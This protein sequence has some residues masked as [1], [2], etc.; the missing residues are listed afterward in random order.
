MVRSKTLHGIQNNTKNEPSRVLLI[1]N[2]Q[3]PTTTWNDQSHSFHTQLISLHPSTS[4]NT[5]QCPFHATKSASTM[6]SSTNSVS[7]QMDTLKPSVDE[8]LTSE[9]LKHDHSPQPRVKSFEEIPGPKAWPFIGHLLD[10]LKHK[11]IPNIY[12]YELCEQYGDM[13]RLKIPGENMLIV[14]HPVIIEEL[15]KK[16][17]RREYLKS[18]RYYKQ[19]H[20]ITL[21]PIEMTFF[22]DW[23]EIRNL[24]NVAMKPENLEKVSLPQI[25]ELNGDF[26]RTL[27]KKLK[28]TDNDDGLKYRLP[29]AFDVTSLYTFKAVAKTFLGV[30]VTEELEQQMPWTIYE[31]VEQA[32]R[33]TDIALQL[34]NKPPLY[35]YIKTSEYKEME[36]LMDKIYDGCKL[37]IKMFEQNPNPKIPRLKELVDQRA[38]GMEQA[39]KKSEGVLSAFLNGGVDITSRIMVNQMYRLAHHVEYQ[40]KLFEELK[41]LFGEP[42]TEEFESENGLEI[43]WEKYK[44]MKLVKNFLEETMRLNSFSYMTSGRW[45]VQDFELNGYLIPKDTRIFIMNYHPSLK[46]EFVPR[47]KEFIAERHEKGHPLAPKSMYSSLPFGIGARKCPG[48]RIASTEL[49]MSLINLVRH[50]RLTHENPEKF[51]ESSHDQ[52]MLYINSKN[53]P[54]Y[55]IPR[56]HMKPI[57]EKHV[58]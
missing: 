49:H 41:G 20:D 14:S 58:K 44:K 40:D 15:V 25:T 43:T 57:L 31:F 9:T 46:D 22:E 1:N 4:S 7:L 30:K 36:F 26:L 21:A 52:S 53:H 10:L 42:T 13:V 16:E 48:S 38:V 33:A 47:A 55:L 3:I 37:L 29:N 5:S 17:E 50:F 51:P 54:L 32:V 23:Q 28:R 2:N 45:A 12:F 8:N 34:D 56:D 35:Q 39:H 27:V 6:V 19:Q 18:N 24:Y 11:G